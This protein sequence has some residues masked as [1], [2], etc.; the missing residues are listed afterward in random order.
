[1]I[2]KNSK[3]EL[4]HST[5]LSYKYDFSFKENVVINNIDLLDVFSKYRVD[6]D[7]QVNLRNTN[8]EVR[9]S[10]EINKGKLDGYKIQLILLSI[11]N[12][13]DDNLTDKEKNY[14][15]HT[16]VGMTINQVRE[17]IVQFTGGCP[18]GA[19]QLPL[20]DL[21]DL[22]EK[23]NRVINKKNEKKTGRSNKKSANT[24]D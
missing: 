1:M 16:A 15:I 23:K 11:Y 21:S 2:A 5:L 13:V 7:Y 14:W 20:I 4:L 24:S 8:F 3:L 18:F 9:I 22:I 19:Y 10:T 6:I 17:R 12:I